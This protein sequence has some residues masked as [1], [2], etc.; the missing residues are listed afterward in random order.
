MG[1]YLN[2]IALRFQ[3]N[4]TKRRRAAEYLSEAKEKTRAGVAHSAI[5]F[6]HLLDELSVPRT[7]GTPPLFQSLM[8]YLDFPGGSQPFGPDFTMDLVRFEQSK[9]NYELSV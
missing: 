3:H 8:D 2:M 5:L 7:A 1:K 6:E 9:A 4:T